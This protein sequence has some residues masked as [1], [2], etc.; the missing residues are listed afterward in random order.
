MIVWNTVCPILLLRLD[1]AGLLLWA[2]WVG[3]I[4]RLLYG[5]RSSSTGPQHGV[6][7]Q[8]WVVP[9]LQLT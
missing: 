4:S 5:W 8:V 1:A 6:Q 3:D 9:R 7:Q 2:Q